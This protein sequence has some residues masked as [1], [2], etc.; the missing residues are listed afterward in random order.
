MTLSG[1]YCIFEIEVGDLGKDKERE[2]IAKRF[3]GQTAWNLRLLG[4]DQRGAVTKA[5]IIQS[6][7]VEGPS[8]G[9][10]IKQKATELTEKEGGPL[11]KLA[12]PK[13]TSAFYKQIQNLVTSGYLKE[14]EIQDDPHAP[15]P[16]RHIY[17]LTV[18][19]SIVALQMQ[20]VID[21]LPDFY[22]QKDPADHLYRLPGLTPF[23]VWQE[24]GIAKA[25]IEHILRGA[26]TR[27]FA[28]EPFEYGTEEREEELRDTWILQLAQAFMNL[29]KPGLAAEIK[30]T[31]NEVARA[32]RILR[33]DPRSRDAM[34]AFNNLASAV[35]E[36]K[37]NIVADAS[38]E[39]KA[40]MNNLSNSQGKVSA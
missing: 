31:R 11:K 26:I 21:H 4:E 5:A 10:R 17:D 9:Y 3:I 27:M 33:E 15:G 6:I 16:E 28:I 7:A 24:N 12:S 25:L 18:K 38:R 29:A 32:Q 30:I 34:D 22:K 20:Y 35:Y 23:V 8:W 13:D 36:K 19:G 37:A 1:S 2:K 14:K 40:F 39:F